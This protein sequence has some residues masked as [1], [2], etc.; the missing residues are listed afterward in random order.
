MEMNARW[1]LVAGL[2]LALAM[3]VATAGP[4][5]ISTFGP[6]GSFETGSQ[7]NYS[8]RG[9]LPILSASPATQFVAD[10]T[11]ELSTISVAVGDGLAGSHFTF[12]INLLSDA[13]GAPGTVLESWTGL[14]PNYVFTAGGTPVTVTDTLGLWLNAGTSYWL[15]VA[16]A[17]N[18][19]RL[20]IGGTLDRWNYNDLGIQ[21]NS[22]LGGPLH[23]V[24]SMTAPA[25]EVAGN[26]PEPAS[27]GM[28]G[29][30]LLGLAALIR[31]LRR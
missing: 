9:S 27:F 16:P 11:F 24:S 22:T 8:V 13:G 19:N 30:A 29:V 10:Y 17:Y 25:Y 18:G 23:L 7:Q 12:D 1:Y 28:T 5:S 21:A 2:Q 6:G 31:K 14:T 3:G 4:I 26:T 20:G 15:Q